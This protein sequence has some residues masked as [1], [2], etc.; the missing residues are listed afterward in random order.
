M[1]KIG[2]YLTASPLPRKR[3]AASSAADGAG[4]R[5]FALHRR[6]RPY[7]SYTISNQAV[8]AL[9]GYIVDMELGTQIVT[10][11]AIVT[12]WPEEHDGICRSGRFP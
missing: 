3:W 7:L 10:S 4:Q 11:E 9:R 12:G 8:P 1:P 5:R 2:G 6:P